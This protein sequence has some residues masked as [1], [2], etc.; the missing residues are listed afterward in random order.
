MLLFFINIWIIKDTQLEGMWVVY[1]PGVASGIALVMANHATK[2]MSS[3]NLKK[4]YKWR[5]R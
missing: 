4:I 5:T 3:M 1:F 2:L